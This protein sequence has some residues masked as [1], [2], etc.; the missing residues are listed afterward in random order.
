MQRKREIPFALNASSFREA[1]EDANE[2]IQ[3]KNGTIV[4]LKEDKV[5]GD[6]IGIIVIKEDI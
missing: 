5:D 1:I 4:E 3:N 6:D 2:S